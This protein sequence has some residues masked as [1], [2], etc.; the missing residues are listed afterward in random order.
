MCIFEAI[1]DHKLKYSTFDSELWVQNELQK[2]Q[3]NPSRADDDHSLLVGFFQHSDEDIH[4]LDFGGSL[5]ADR[6]FANSDEMLKYCTEI[7][8]KAKNKNLKTALGG[9]V[10][11]EAIEFIRKLNSDKL[12]DKFETRKLV[13]HKDA[14]KNIHEGLPIGVKFE[15]LWLK[16]KRRYYHR[17][18]DEDEKRILML[19]KRIKDTS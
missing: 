3:E 15:L 6:S 10:A 18:R 7:F 17:V 5:G 4:V 1:T 13:F 12:I 2:N 14:V 9:A 16:S 8:Q 19:E 11:T